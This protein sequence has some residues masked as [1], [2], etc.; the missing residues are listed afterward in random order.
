[1]TPEHAWKADVW[2]DIAPMWQE[3]FTDGVD[4]EYTDQILPLVMQHLPTRPTDRPLR[5]LDVG[6]GEG[7]VAR[8]IAD[9][10]DAHLIGMDSTIAQL[11]A[12]RFR[13]GSPSYLRATA[14]Q[15]PFRDDWFDVVI[16]CLVFEHV[17]EL[18][19][20]L[21]EIERVAQPAGRFLFFLN[22]PL[23]QAPGSGWIDDHILDE[24]YW[25]MGPYLQETTTLE[26]V[27]KGVHVPF[28]HRPL[29]TYVNAMSEVGLRLD[30]M[31]EPAPPP[32]FLAQAEEY[33][34]SSAI[35][36]LLF[37]QAEKAFIR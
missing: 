5:I 9:R 32:A 1:M 18:K 13:G 34:D 7:Q 30:Y 19:V 6:T 37:L 14:T 12:A 16:V 20:V 10:T 8:F 11:D 28:V 4:P 2:E 24:Q 22:H 21:E 23:L 3:N 31:A 25:R 29:S 17:Q 15:L 33:K 35:P 36:R 27:A 26:E